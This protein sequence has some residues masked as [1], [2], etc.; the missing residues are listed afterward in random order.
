[1]NVLIGSFGGRLAA[2]LAVVLL[3]AASAAPAV[4]GPADDGE[5]AICDRALSECLGQAGGAAL[6]LDWRTVIKL[7]FICISGYNFCE[8][9]VAPYIREEGRP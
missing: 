2:A 5:A 1:M 8:K 3:L 4:A 9:Y 6:T 7:L